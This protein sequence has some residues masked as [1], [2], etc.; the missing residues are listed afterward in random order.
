MT[1]KSNVYTFGAILLEIMSGRPAL[2]RNRPKL[3]ER[4]LV[5]W[6]K[7][8]L[9]SNRLISQVMDARIEGEY[10]VHEVKKVAKIVMQCVTDDPN[11]RPT[12]DDVLSAMEQLMHSSDEGSSRTYNCGVSN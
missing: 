7:P 4:N 2:D 6:A 11:L 3:E 12:M 9:L 1:K 10:P 8:Y 5:K